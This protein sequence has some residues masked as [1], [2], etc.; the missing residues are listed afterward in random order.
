MFALHDYTIVG[1][2]F[3][4][5]SRTVWLDLRPEGMD[6]IY[7]MTLQNVTRFC[8]QEVALQNVILEYKVYRESSQDVE[9]S[10]ACSLLG[11][12]PSDLKL[13]P[14]TQRLVYFE[15][16]AGAAIACLADMPSN[17]LLTPAP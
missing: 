16:S 7:T 13:D 17:P 8:A 4:E 9:F 12:K 14:S 10:Y 3:D 2:R 11:L 15:P 6:T 1:I 5:K